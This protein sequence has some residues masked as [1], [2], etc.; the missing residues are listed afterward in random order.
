MGKWAQRGSPL[1]FKPRKSVPKP[2]NHSTQL[3][4]WPFPFKR[5]IKLPLLVNLNPSDHVSCPLKSPPL[6]SGT[7]C[8]NSSL[9][10]DQEGRPSLLSSFL[11]A[12]LYTDMTSSGEGQRDYRGAVLH[13]THLELVP[14]QHIRIWSVCNG[15]AVFYCTTDHSVCRW[16]L[17]GTL[18][19]FLV[20]GWGAGPGCCQVLASTV[21]P[22]PCLQSPF[23]PSTPP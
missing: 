11:S 1:R 23:F 3:P 10:H 12:D 18:A 8:D 20:G 6:G 22:Q 17:L 7:F 9:E 16:S 21:R 13:L 4:A 5:T 2:A 14:Y 15:R 19:V